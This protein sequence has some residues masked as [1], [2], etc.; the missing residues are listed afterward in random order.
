MNRT[1]ASYIER[2]PLNQLDTYATICELLKSD[3]V[4]NL[5]GGCYITCH[6]VCEILTNHPRLRRSAIH[7][8]GK[9]NGLDHSW[10]VIPSCTVNVPE[11]IVDVYPWCSVIVNPL[12]LVKCYATDAWYVPLKNNL[13]NGRDLCH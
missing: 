3:L 5:V 2:L 7:V 4:P 12:L 10:L 13:N 1:C 8:K 6:Q 11:L 9:F